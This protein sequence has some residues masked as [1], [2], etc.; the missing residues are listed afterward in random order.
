M[1]KEELMRTNKLVEK[2]LAEYPMARNSDMY[3]Y[4]RVVKELNPDACKQPFVN[5]ISNLKEL[6]LPCIETVGRCRRKLQEKHPEY[7]SDKQVQEYRE[8]ARLE[9]EDYARS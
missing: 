9:F 2:I 8:Q 5:V 4:V 7:W 3:L 6:G 1:K